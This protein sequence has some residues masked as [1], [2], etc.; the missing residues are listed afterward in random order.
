[1]KRVD[2]CSGTRLR[3][4]RSNL[5]RRE[6]LLT[7]RVDFLRKVVLGDHI[8]ADA[9]EFFKNGVGESQHL[10]GAFLAQLAQPQRV[11]AWSVRNLV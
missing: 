1:M 5:Y 6:E 2:D 8:L 7:A 3:R 11:P 4:C 10:N 9:V